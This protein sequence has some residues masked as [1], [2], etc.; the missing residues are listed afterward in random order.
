MGLPKRFV[1]HLKFDLV[2][3]EFMNN[4]FRSSAFPVC[5]S[6]LLL[7]EFLLSLTAK[8]IRIVSLVF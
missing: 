2:H 8:G 7:F 6:F 3:L 1:L 4:F 5:R